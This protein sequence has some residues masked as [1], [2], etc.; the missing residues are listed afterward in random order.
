MNLRATAEKANW[1]VLWQAKCVTMYFPT[2]LHSCY[3]ITLLHR[4]SDVYSDKNSLLAV[5]F[6]K[7]SDISPV[8]VLDN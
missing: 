8:Y 4:S 2:F 6:K 3:F 7:Y 1:E 5:S